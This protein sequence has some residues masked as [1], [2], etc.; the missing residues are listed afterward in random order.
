MKHAQPSGSEAGHFTV[1]DLSPKGSE[2]ITISSIARLG[3]ALT[4]TKASKVAG[5]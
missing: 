2:M 1:M 4:G 3:T 5:D